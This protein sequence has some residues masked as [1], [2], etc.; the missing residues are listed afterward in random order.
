[1]IFTINILLDINLTETTLI[2]V[3]MLNC[4]HFIIL[5]HSVEVKNAK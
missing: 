4:F 5:E 2:F 3:K 1:V